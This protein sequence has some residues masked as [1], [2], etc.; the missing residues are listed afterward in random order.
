MTE[1]S[2]LSKL[3]AEIA[4][5]P[6]MAWGV[7]CN[8]AMPIK[9]ATGVSHRKANEAAAHLMQHLFAYDITADERYKYEKS[10][11]QHYA[12]IAAQ[13]IE[14]AAADETPQQAQP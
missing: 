4:A 11:A 8:I 7:H 13:G 10:G 6:E 9:D 5:D 12:E 2:G 3:S 1:L 14:A